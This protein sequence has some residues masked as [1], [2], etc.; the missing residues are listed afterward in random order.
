VLS[1]GIAM[2]AAT[3]YAAAVGAEIGQ[4]ELKH[5][6]KVMNYVNFQYRN[7]QEKKRITIL[8]P[9]VTFVDV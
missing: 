6:L 8:V 1:F 9:F 4:D 7:L 5:A 2:N 3:M